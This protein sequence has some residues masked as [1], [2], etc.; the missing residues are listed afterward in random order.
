[1]PWMIVVQWLAALAVVAFGL[2]CGAAP[3]ATGGVS[4]SSEPGPV[5]GLVV[6][7]R[8]N[9]LEIEMGSAAEKAGVKR[10]DVLKRLGGTGVTSAAEARGRFQ[11][12]KKGENMAVI[13]A[14][15]G[16]DMTLQVT[17]A[18]RPDRP[19]Q[20]TPTAVPQD[21]MYL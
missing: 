9:V 10:G 11:Q 8:M 13:V 2:A 5:L 16:Q 7:Q 17:V 19:G 15:G 12:A 14:R 20:P 6:D 21:Q 3:P 18:T 4:F 1:M